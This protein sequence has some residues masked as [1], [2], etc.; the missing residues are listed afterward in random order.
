MKLNHTGAGAGVLLTISLTA[1][2]VLFHQPPGLAREDKPAAK[3]TNAAANPT[4]A[5]TA[6][7]AS[8]AGLARE[9]DRILAGAAL[10]KSR[11]GVFVMSAKDGRVLY[12]HNSDQLFT[13]ASNM[14]VYTTAVAL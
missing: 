9:I 7:T 2:F 8:D 12:T 5:G 1:V 6:T 4:S 3:S 14:K 10:S 11:Y 13:P